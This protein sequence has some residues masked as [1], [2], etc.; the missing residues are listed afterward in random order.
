MFPSQFSLLFSNN[1]QQYH[2]PV[3]DLSVVSQMSPPGGKIRGCFQCSKRRII[4]DNTE[5]TCKKCRKKGIECS[6][7][8]RIR[9]STGVAQRGRLKGSIIPVVDPSPEPTLESNIQATPVP[10]KIR[11]KNDR[12][13]RTTRKNVKRAG[14]GPSTRQATSISIPR[15]GNATVCTETFHLQQKDSDGIDEYVDRLSD[16]AL[17]P[18]AG[19]IHKWLA[20]LNPQTRMLM[21]HF[22][23]QVAPV[24]VLLDHISNGYRDI[25]LP[26][27]CEDELVQRA[28]GVVASQ[29]L[30][31]HSPS[32]QSFADQGR[33]TLI[34][35]L[36]RD[37]TSPSR[38]F[39]TST[40]AT[41]IVLLVGET[42]TGSSEYAHL[43]RTLTYLVQ[44]ADQI[45]SS[46]ARQF[47]SQQTHMFEFLG[48]PLL[49]EHQGVTVLSFPLEHYLDWTCYNLPPDS[50]HNHMLHLSRVAFIKASQIYLG[51]VASNDDQWQLLQSLMELV[52]QIDPNQ[53]G[54]HALVW[55]C[56]IAAAD[57]TDPEHR[58][59]FVNRMNLIFA[60]VKFHNI[61][62]G[63]QTLPA[64]WSQQ[65]SSRWTKNLSQLAP[66]LIM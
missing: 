18:V 36:C 37:S 24:M 4:C 57:S 56:F 39:T 44:N 43:L 31:L 22:S 45:A 20:P 65:G 25:L 63:V 21:S 30:A 5:P 7:P 62:A 28:V 23:E 29:H 27:A 50:E 16:N 13:A 19:S 33:A 38:V 52:S 6:G 32:Y 9:F 10:R 8:G 41:L 26:L 58:S 40:W 35:R 54:S 49:G 59:F 66:I 1:L 14:A 61:P 2:H 46:S 11:W 12:P 15:N 34:S 51:R 48:Q 47:L 17:I 64:I 55:V 60:K 53:M 3:C 42:I